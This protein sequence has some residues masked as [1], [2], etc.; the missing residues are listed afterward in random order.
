META[1]RERW[2]VR[3]S[4]IRVAQASEVLS[5]GR[6]PHWLGC[7][8]PALRAM[9]ESLTVMILSSILETVLRRT[10]MRKDAGVS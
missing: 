9:S 5:T 1:Q 3:T 8:R 10:I 2:R 6:E 7:R 4:W